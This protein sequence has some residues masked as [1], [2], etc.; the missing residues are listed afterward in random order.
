MMPQQ[1]TPK[2]IQNLIEHLVGVS[3]YVRDQIVNGNKVEYNKR[4]LLELEQSIRDLRLSL[5]K[6]YYK[7][8]HTKYAGVFYER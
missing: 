8:K 4:Y 1:L 2:A 5:R 3:D 6:R 7:N